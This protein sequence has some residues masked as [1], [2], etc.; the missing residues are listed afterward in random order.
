MEMYTVSYGKIRKQSTIK[1]F[2]KKDIQIKEQRNAIDSNHRLQ[3]NK[4]RK[5]FS[6]LQ[7]NVIMGCYFY[8]SLLKLILN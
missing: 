1:I 6:K 5:M 3:L 8:F 7:H 4:I 2:P